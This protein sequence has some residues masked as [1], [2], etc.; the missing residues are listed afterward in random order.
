[1]KFP[2]SRSGYCLASLL[3]L[4][5]P[6]AESA[7]RQAPE[8]GKSINIGLLIPDSISCAAREGASLAVRK[9]NQKGGINGSRINLVVKSMEGLWGTGSKQAVSLIFEDSV[10]AILGSHDGR[11]AHLAEQVSA[12][13]R[14]VFLSAWTADPT[15]AQ[16]FVPWFFNCVP[17]D[18]EQAATIAGEICKI[19]KYSRV[20][21]ISD[22]DYDSGSMLKHLLERMKSEGMKDPFQIKYSGDSQEIK[23]IMNK[24]RGAD[25]ECVI[26][27]VKPPASLKIASQMKTDKINMPVYCSLDQMNEDLTGGLPLDKYGHMPGAVA[28][29]AFDGMN[30]LINAV[31]KSGTDR[32]EMQKALRGSI[33]EGVT[34]TIRFDERGNRD[35]QPSFAE[36]R[37]GIPVQVK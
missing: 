16:A 15:L 11:N 17:N 18:M 26:L 6:L 13:A 19:Q 5:L 10:V 33:Y 37:D 1:M 20:A 25:P 35:E 27:L 12:K 32:Y 31:R 28:A 7:A 36:I 4:F 3:L 29:Y 21:I 23:E 30:I 9:A 34:G 14:V 8:T 2:Y 22:N 24:V